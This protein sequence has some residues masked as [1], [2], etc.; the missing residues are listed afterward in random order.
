M[1]VRKLLDERLEQAISKLSDESSSALVRPASRPEFGDYQ[2]NGV[3]AVAKKLRKNPRDIASLVIKEAKTNGIVDKA[4]VAGPGFINLFLHREF[5]SQ[6]LSTSKLL[7]P[8]GSVQKIVVDYSSPNLAK[9]MHIGHLR[10]A[11]IGDAVVRSLESL[12]H[13][14]LRQNHTGD[15]GTPF[16]KLIAYFKQA[17][18][19]YK[20]LADIEKFYVEANHKFNTDDDFAEASRK[21]VVNLHT[22]DPDTIRTWEKFID[23]SINHMQRVYDRIG[24]SL[25][26]SHIR[27]ESSYNTDL[28]DVLNDLDHAGLLS[29]SDGAKCVFLEEFKGKDNKPLPVLVQKSDGGY[30]YQTTDLAAVKYRSNIL[31]ADR[32][33]YFTDA[34]QNLHF[35]MLFAVARAAN[36]TNGKTALEHHPFGKIV[37]GNG[38]PFSTRDGGTIP[39]MKLVDE[40]LERARNIVL[41][42]SR[43]LPEEKIDEVVNAVAIG[44]LKYAD[45]SKNRTNDYMFDWDNMLS[46]EG[47]TAPYIQYGFAR[48]MS[49]FS[50]GKVNAK[51]QAEIT[52]SNNVEHALAVQLVRFQETVEQVAIEAMPHYL[53]GYLYDLTTLFMRFYENCPVLE[54][55]TPVQESRL[56]LCSKTAATLK[57]GLNLL[58][59]S[60]V[61]QM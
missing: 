34:R 45:L 10:S 26:P 53:C 51:F 61:S 19:K 41:K 4:V 9:E 55:P 30:L 40:A 6:L 43:D 42:R 23:A 25:K 2:A 60:A 18:T 52:I 14:V 15:W 36:F 16:G 48:I 32:V 12:G 1:N 44:A 11:I 46:F 27:G 59:I 49:L 58:G 31:Q 38:K 17:H 56:A 20:N 33:L 28:P 39:L 47:N 21:A 54:A 24:I 7:T 57:C 3:M 5:L 22:G 8:L 29:M 35:K 50:R 37:D 13:E